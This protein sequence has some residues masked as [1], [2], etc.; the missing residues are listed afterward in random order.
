MKTITTLLSVLLLG[1]V[2]NTSAQLPSKSFTAYGAL[3]LS[4]ASSPNFFKEGWGNGLHG[5]AQLGFS[6]LPKGEILLNVG[7]HK[8][9]SDIDFLEIDEGGDLNVLLVGGDFKFN[10]G[11]PA[12][13]IK[14]YLFAGAGVAVI[15]Y[16]DVTYTEGSFTVTES[17][18]LRK[19]LY[20][21][22]GGE[23]EFSRFFIKVKYVSIK[24]GTFDEEDVNLETY[25]N[26]SMIPISIGIKF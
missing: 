22:I 2:T 23:I 26:A 18:D 6:M 19:E 21:E 16:T 15:Y 7:Y 3:G 4:T 13:P 17:F 5:N 25:V 20:F 9:G 14:P 1:V 12:A 11:V 24:N 8:F 10:L